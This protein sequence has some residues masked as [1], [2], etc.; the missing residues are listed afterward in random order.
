MA[1]FVT[2]NLESNECDICHHD[3]GEELISYILNDR[4]LQQQKRWNGTNKS[5]LTTQD[6]QIRRA[7]VLCLDRWD[8]I[9]KKSLNRFNLLRRSWTSGKHSRS[10]TKTDSNENLNISRTWTAI[11]SHS[12]EKLDYHNNSAPQF[13]ER[14]MSE[15]LT[16][17]AYL[18]NAEPSGECHVKG[19]C[20]F[21][22]FNIEE[23]KERISWLNKN[24]KDV[25]TQLIG[26][27]QERDGIREEIHVRRIAIGQLL[28]LQTGA[29]RSQSVIGLDT[30]Q[31][32]SLL[33]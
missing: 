31:R 1:E 33:V 30:H 20:N 21:T 8:H 11:K 26:L 14:R 5:K 13:S 32:N 16:L 19:S 25:S 4:C 2:I 17:R 24:I 12:E 9:M 6:D 18:T 29:T 27:L 23:L 7:H 10:L 28:K 22:R 3:N 15:P